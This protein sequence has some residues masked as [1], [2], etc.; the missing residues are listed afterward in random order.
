LKTFP[1]ELFVK[2]A[3]QGALKRR[4]QAEDL[5]G[6]FAFLASDDASFITGQ[7]FNIDGGR[8]FL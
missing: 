3:Q 1:A 6:T 5:I 4:Q 7:T 8:T 2:L